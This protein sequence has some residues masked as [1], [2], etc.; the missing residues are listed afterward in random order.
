MILVEISWHAVPRPHPAKREPAMPQ[1]YLGGGAIVAICAAFATI[2]VGQAYAMDTALHLGI[3]VRPDDS[4][5][6][7]PRREL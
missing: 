7:P 1:C 2:G 6:S 3:L 4:P 5:I